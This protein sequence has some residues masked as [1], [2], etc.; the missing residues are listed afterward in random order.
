MHGWARIQGDLG[1]TITIH[2]SVSLGDIEHALA[3]R[4]NTEVGR[5]GGRLR[6]KLKKAAKKVGKSKVLRGVVKVARK[7]LD[8]PIVQAALASNPYGQA[9][10]AARKGLRMGIQAI[11][12]AKGAKQAIKGVY[13]SYKRGNPGARN[14]LSMVR[15]GMQTYK[16]LAPAARAA[17]AG[18]EPEAFRFI[19]GEMID[20]VEPV[21]AVSGADW[22]AVM[23]E[24]A[25][26]G[27]RR[28]RGSWRKKLKKGLKQL[29][30]PREH[31]KHLKR[32]AK[33]VKKNPMKALLDPRSQ[34]KRTFAGSHL[35]LIAGAHY[36]VIGEDMDALATFAT[37]GA[38]EPL[39][40]NLASV[41]E[42]ASL[43][44]PGDLTA[45][46]AVLNGRALMAARF[47]A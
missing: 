15:K 19:A 41:P 11:K 43:A 23:G 39:R 45:R 32:T 42:N 10:L 35:E 31:F 36:D 37:A 13:R 4:L 14:M 34:L 16:K 1:D 6:N 5:L 26:I 20:S 22:I 25:E 38:F 2:D 17:L 44:A 12:G 30:D 3:R 9:F 33:A 24:S 29:H 8:N 18:A 47:A 28:R 40:R 7:A 46:G 21:A 27:R